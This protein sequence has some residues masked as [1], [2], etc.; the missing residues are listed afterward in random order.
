MAGEPRDLMAPIEA[1]LQ[2]ERAF[3]LGRAGNRL[4]AALAEL[5]SNERPALADDLLDDAATAV[6]HYLIIR[7]SLGMY[8]HTETLA[9]YGVPGKV[10]ARVGVVRRA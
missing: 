1:E 2:A 8:D 5:A 6:W 7:E 3:A 10:L 4:E 9:V